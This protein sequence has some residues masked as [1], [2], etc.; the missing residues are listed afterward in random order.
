[1]TRVDSVAVVQVTEAALAIALQVVQ[2]SVALKDPGLQV[3]AF[4]P[5][6]QVFIIPGHELQTRPFL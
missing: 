3:V 2:A 4:G 1:V 6:A 5:A